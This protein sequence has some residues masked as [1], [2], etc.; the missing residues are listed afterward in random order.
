MSQF[1]HTI[2]YQ[3]LFNLLIILY[4]A[5]PGH[6]IGIAIIGIIFLVKLILYP[7]TKTTLHAQRK[8]QDLQPRLKEIKEKHKH[9]KAAQTQETMKLYQEEGVNPM[10]G[11]LPL[12]IQLPLLIALFQVFRT[13]FDAKSLVNLYPFVANPGQL[14]P[15]FLGLVDLS[16][17]SVALSIFA[18]IAQ[19]FQTYI[20]SGKEAFTKKTHDTGQ[21]MQKQMAFMTPIFTIFISLSL[22]SALAFY[23][24][25]NTVLSIGEHYLPNLRLR[26]SS[27]RR[28][29]MAQR[30][31]IS[32]QK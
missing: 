23:W 7:F 31:P 32:K 11:C 9:N 8:M 14:N 26:I 18:G 20:I 12:L 22:P 19:F 25:V 29:G 28:G 21:A 24:I 27:F 13:G 10:S 6:D 15:L 3:P 16:K 30:L 17:G 4:N 2:L 5:I 1:F